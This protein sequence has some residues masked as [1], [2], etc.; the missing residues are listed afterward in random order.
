[1]TAELRV[2]D[3]L[4][5]VGAEA[6]DLM[7]WLADDA[8]RQRGRFTMALSGGKTP[9]ALY[10]RLASPT[11][12]ARIRTLAADYFF[13]DERGVPP[14]HAESNFG[15]A[16]AAFFAP[17]GLPADRIHRM[18]ADAS[19]LDAASR[20]YEAQIRARLGASAPAFPRFDLILLGI[21]DDGHTASL[22]PHAPQLA[23]RTRAVVPSE[24]P[25]G[26]AR[27][28]TFTFPLINAARTVLFLV[29]G[30][31]KAD[32]VH[33]ILD[34]RDADPSQYPA[35]RVQPT[36][37]RLIWILDDAAAAKLDLTARRVPSDEE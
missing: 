9:Q 13:G 27:R 3:D 34:R 36:D 35:R 18:P 10:E 32:A 11:L 8:I 19:D 31:A 15:A 7:L 21:G 37:G 6:A 25:R 24:S 5:A 22:F 17:L 14:D 16:R 23:E 1:M 12:G 2:V 29:T 4:H 26:I 28:M 30:G 20:E 33:H